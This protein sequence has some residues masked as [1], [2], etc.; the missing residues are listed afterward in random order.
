MKELGDSEKMKL[1]RAKASLEIIFSYN[2]AG[3]LDEARALLEAMKDLGDSIEVSEFR[4]SASELLSQA[5]PTKP[6]YPEIC[7]T[8]S[9]RS[10]T[11]TWCWGRQNEAAKL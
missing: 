1:E 9:R 2:D 5:Y 11:R 6:A 4:I 7:S 8:A 10:A 3:R